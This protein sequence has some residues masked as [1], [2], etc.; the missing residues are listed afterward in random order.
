LIFEDFPRWLGLIRRKLIKSLGLGTSGPKPR[1]DAIRFIKDVEDSE[2]R[3]YAVGN[4]SND[5]FW[6][7]AFSSGLEEY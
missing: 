7:G 4:N 2:E 3:G 6:I 5:I 1:N